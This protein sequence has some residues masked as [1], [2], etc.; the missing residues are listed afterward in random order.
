MVNLNL[1]RSEH[2][3]LAAAATSQAP[4]RSDRIADKKQSDE[5][6]PVVWDRKFLG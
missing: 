4:E 1:N 6:Q 2:G 3:T 5:Q